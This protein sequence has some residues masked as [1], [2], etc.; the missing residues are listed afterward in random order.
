ME[1]YILLYGDK[2][3]EDNVCIKNMFKQNIQINLGWTDFDYN[4]NIKII[5]EEIEKGV[6]QFIFSGLEIGWDKLVKYL[7]EKGK[8][9]KVICNTQDSLLYYDY[10]RENFFRLLELS[11][12]KFIDD[13]AFL[14]KGQYEVYRSLGYRCSFLRENY[15]L[16]DDKKEEIQGSNEKQED[17][18][19]INIGIY[20]LNYTWDKNIFNQLCIPKYIENSN[21]NYNKIDDRMEDFL[22]TMEIKSTPCKI[23][24]IND[25]NIRKEVEKNDITIA[26]SF[27]E[28]FHVIFFISMEQGIPCIIGNTEDFFDLNN[29]EEKELEKYVVT[30]AEDNSIINSKMVEE[31]LKNKEKIVELYKKWKQ[32]YNNLAKSSIEEFVRK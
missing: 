30:Q 28:Y 27:T 20:P 17:G 24:N 14:R 7:K 18:K 5:D 10:E 6:E 23:E 12:E 31:C 32:K 3:P 21:L 15:I 19:V 11:K 1:K 2:K 25:E 16:E 4:H 26:T 13:I 8:K 9:V 29:E 22:N